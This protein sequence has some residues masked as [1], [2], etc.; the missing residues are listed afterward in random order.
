[1]FQFILIYGFIDY[2]P[3]SF[4]DYVFPPW[5]EAIGWT[6]AMVSIAVIF[7]YIAWYL[8][9]SEGSFKE[10]KHTCF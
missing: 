4:G 5:A 9:S 2:A 3:A 6:L 8:A 7:V 1:M 10:V